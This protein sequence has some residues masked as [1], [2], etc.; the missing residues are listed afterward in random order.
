MQAV[1][2]SLLCIIS[3][4]IALNS[5]K[6]KTADGRTQ[7]QTEACSCR[8]HPLSTLPA[9][10]PSIPLCSNTNYIKPSLVR[11]NTWYAYCLVTTALLVLA[12]STLC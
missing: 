10:L 8:A 12:F 5:S 6:Q 3:P 2:F 9:L 1:K 4:A 7:L 11:Y